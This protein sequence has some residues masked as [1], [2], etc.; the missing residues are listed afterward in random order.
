MNAREL[1]ALGIPQDCVGI[2]FDALQGSSLISQQVD[3]T[4]R[5]GEL[6]V[7]PEAFTARP[8]LWRIGQ[9]RDLGARP[10][11]CRQGILGPQSARNPFRFAKWGER[12]DPGS[13]EQITAACELQG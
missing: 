8:E 9:V 12:D 10:A 7:S 2:A 13:V 3:A 11:R 6:L 1:V 4:Q 5:I